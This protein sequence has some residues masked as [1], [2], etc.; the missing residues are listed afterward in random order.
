MGYIQDCE[1][2]RFLTEFEFKRYLQVRVQVRVLIMLFFEF[3]FGKNDRV[4]QVRVRSPGYI[5]SQ[6]KFKTLKRVFQAFPQGARPKREVRKVNVRVLFVMFINY[7]VLSFKIALYTRD[8]KSSPAL[9][10]T[11]RFLMS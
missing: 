3:E 11:I 4:Q 9:C 7:S 5:P 1:L 6:V 2:N 10:I 8:S